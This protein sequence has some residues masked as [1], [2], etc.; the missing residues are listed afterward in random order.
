MKPEHTIS[1]KLATGTTVELQWLVYTFG[2]MKIMFEAGVVR[3][4]E[5]KS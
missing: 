2:T 5:C 3:V 1:L 4:S